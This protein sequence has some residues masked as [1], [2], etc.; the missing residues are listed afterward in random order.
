MGHNHIH[1]FVWDTRDRTSPLSWLEILEENE[2]MYFYP[3]SF[4]GMHT[5]Q[6]SQITSLH[7]IHFFDDERA[8]L[9]TIPT[10]P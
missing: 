5:T 8:R 4:V 2:G 9:E 1:F 3:I 7:D 6:Y 10:K